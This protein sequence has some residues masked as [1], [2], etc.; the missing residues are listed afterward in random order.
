MKAC[1]KKRST[2]SAQKKTTKTSKATSRVA[3]TK[4][5]AAKKSAVKKT[6]SPKTKATPKR[7]SRTPTP[8]KTVKQKTPVSDDESEEEEEVKQTGAVTGGSMVDRFV[9]NSQSYVVHSKNNEVYSCYLTATDV[10]NN[11]NKYYVIQ[12]LNKSGTYSVFTRYG[13]VGYDGVKSM[14]PC[15]TNEGRAINEYNKTKQKKLRKYKEIKIAIKTEEA[16]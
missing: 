6:A 2:R 1:G 7:T 13:R 15:G 11:N 4:K 10:K 3:S 5:T 9:P 14:S 8:R 12:V 16:K